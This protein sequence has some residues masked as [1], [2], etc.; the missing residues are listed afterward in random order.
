MQIT[1]MLSICTMMYILI[2][3]GTIIFPLP[4][5]QISVDKYALSE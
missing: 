3:P 1:H 5:L 2:V 4:I